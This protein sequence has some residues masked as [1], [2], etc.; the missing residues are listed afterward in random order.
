[1][2]PLPETFRSIRKDF[3]EISTKISGGFSMEQWIPISEAAEM[4][5]LTER[6]V[7]YRVSK[8][9]MQSKMEDGKRFVLMD[10]EE[11]VSGNGSGE[12]QGNFQMLLEEKDARI[13]DFQTQVTEKDKQIDHLQQLVAMETRNVA[14][15]TEQLND[16]KLM[17][18]DLRTRKPFWKRLWVWR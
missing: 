8:G 3:I 5:G 6:A 16:S 2:K 7:R 17:L 15:L 1:M 11:M 18:E 14:M 13:S 12:F 10:D 4:L 9:V